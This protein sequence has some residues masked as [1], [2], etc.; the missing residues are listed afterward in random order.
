VS[1]NFAFGSGFLDGDGP[2]HLPSNN[3]VDLALSKSLGE[4][5]TVGLTVIN[6]ANHR[7]LIDASNTFGGTH[8]SEPRQV[9]GEVRWRFGG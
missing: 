6:I 5:W 2:G 4:R 1:A 3:T 9:V 8:W 7:F